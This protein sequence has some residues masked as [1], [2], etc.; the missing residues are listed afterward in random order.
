MLKSFALVL[1]LLSSAP[2]GA[3]IVNAL[4]GRY[5]MEAQGGEV[6]ELRADGSASLGGEATTWS[7]NATQLRVGTDVMVYILEG[8]RLVVAVGGVQVGWRKLGGKA[9]AGAA[10]DHAPAAQ[11]KAG[12]ASAQDAQARQLLTG[13]AWCSFTYN[14]VSGTS[15]TRRVVFQPNGLLS[16]NGG[17][18]TYSSGT[19][20]TYAGQSNA[21]STLR[22]R[23]EGQRLYIDAG[24]GA[25]FQDVGL[26]ATK[27]ANGY[28]ILHADGRE[29]SMCR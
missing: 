23:F 21:A 7:A 13:S 27:N 17:A 26:T 6:L 28:V 22:W 9:R 11:G 24:Q 3:Q 29:Y 10:A 25:G 1:L 12:G 5:Q 14:K 19:G 16:I 18:E 8:N 20:G 15:T 4:V 2:A